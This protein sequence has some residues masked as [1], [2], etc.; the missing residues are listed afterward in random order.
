MGEGGR[1]ETGHRMHFGAL[2][3]GRAPPCWLPKQSILAL[4]HYQPA[5][6][7]HAPPPARDAE[8]PGRWGWGSV[9]LARAGAPTESGRPL[10][11]SAHTGTLVLP[12]VPRSRDPK[13]P[14]GVPLRMHLTPKL[15]AATRV[16]RWGNKGPPAHSLIFC[17][18]PP[19][20]SLPRAAAGTVL[21][22]GSK[23]KGSCPSGQ[24]G[25]WEWPQQAAYLARDLRLTLR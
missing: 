24:E 2:R 12:W 5:P 7:A 17:A 18:P 11:P 15:S 13:V 9:D 10:V 22:I 3:L 14:S 20:L 4:L 6:P 21:G 8:A 23:R 16:L 1:R 25:H 19:T